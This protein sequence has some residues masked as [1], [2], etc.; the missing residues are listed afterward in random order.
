V[1]ITA[2]QNDAQ[3]E[4]VLVLQSDGST[5]RVAVVSGA[6]VDDL[7][8]VSGDL[9]VGQRVSTDRASSFNAPNPFGGGGQ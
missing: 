7:V 1:P 4:Y 6:I 3:G 5:Q 9:Q 2:I 8:V